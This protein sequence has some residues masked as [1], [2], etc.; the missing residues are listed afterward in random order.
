MAHPAQNIN[1]SAFRS[2]FEREKLSGNNFNDWFCQLK[3]VLRV[4]KKMYVIEQSIPPAPAADSAKNVLAEWNAVYDAHNEVACLMLG[5]NTPEL[6]RQF[7]NYSP[8]EMLQGLKSMFEKQGGVERFD[9]I[10][11]FHACKLDDGK[12]VGAYVL[13]MKDYVDQLERLGYVLLS[14]LSVDLILNG[15]TSDFAGFVRNYNMH[16]IRK[17]IGELHALLIEYEKG[18]PKKAATPQVMAIQGGRIQKANKKSQKA[19]G[20]GKGKGKGKDKSYIPKPKNPKPSA[21]DHPQRMTPATTVKSKLALPVLQGLRGARKLEQGALYLYVGNGVRAQVEAIRSFDLVLPNGLVI[22]LDNCHYAPTITRGVV[23]VSRLVNNGFIQ[24]F[25]DYGISISKNDVLYFNVIP[26]NGIYEID[27]YNLVPNVNSIYNVSNKRVKHNLDSIIVA[28]PARWERK[29]FPHC[30]EKENDLLGLIRTDICGPLRH[31]SRQACGIVQQLT[32]LYTPQHNGV[33]ERRNRTLSDMVRSMMNLTTLPLSFWDYA[34]ESAARIFNIVTTKKVDKT[35]YELWNIAWDKVEN[36][37]PQSTPQVPP[38]FEET[39]PPVTH[40]K[41]VDETIRTPMEVEPLDKTQLEDLGLNTYVSLREERGPEPP[42]KPHNLDSFRMKEVDSLTI[43]TPPSPHVASSHP[44][45]TY[46][47][48]HPCIDDP[49]KHYGFKPSLLG[50]SA[51]LVVDISNWEMFDDDWGLESK[52]VS[53]LGKELSLFDR[54][55]K[56]EREVSGR[57]GD[58]EEIQDEDTSPSEN[59]SEIPIEVE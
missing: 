49:K 20:K 56:V 5:S 13:K 17:T 46:C 39:T 53:P 35:P 58:L 59:T 42:T 31:V 23:L 36:L 51:S 16:N 11:T 6:H 25:T 22:C 26:S 18:L 1:H 4:E 28:L 52:E 2:M 47:Y 45:D 3:L 27:M 9:L 44:K 15:L 48:Y 38:S 50:K 12:P 37:N 57:A 10:Q 8:Y 32:P 7:E 33:S 34:L 14:D 54:P 43:N 29:S 55:N 21:K 41:E 30:P 40:P 24:R 19:K